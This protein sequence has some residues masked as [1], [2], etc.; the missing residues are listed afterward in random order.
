M[1]FELFL[2]IDRPRLIDVAFN[3]TL[4]ILIPWAK[5]GIQYNINYIIHLQL[6]M[7]TQWGVYLNLNTLFA[8][9]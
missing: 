3:C 7:C 6:Y 9:L 8:Y 2:A 1:V 4:L 5:A